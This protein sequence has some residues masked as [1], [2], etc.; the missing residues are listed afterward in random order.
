MRGLFSYTLYTVNLLSLVYAATNSSA[1][2]AKVLN[3][4]S[5]LSSPCRVTAIQVAT[6]FEQL[7]PGV[8]DAT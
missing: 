1:P 8:K 2:T 5:H 4:E 6:V 3:G 7:F